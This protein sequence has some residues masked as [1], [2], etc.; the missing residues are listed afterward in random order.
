LPSNVGTSLLFWHTAG[1][2]YK[3]FPSQFAALVGRTAEWAKAN[4]VAFRPLRFHDLRHL[5]AIEWLKSGRSICALQHRLGHTSIKTTERYLGVGYLT[6]EEQEAAKSG[7]E[8][9]QRGAQA[10]LGGTRR[11]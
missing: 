9:A 3:N 7:A 4:G 6:F 2:S 10:T 5:H 8:V 11:A 1:E